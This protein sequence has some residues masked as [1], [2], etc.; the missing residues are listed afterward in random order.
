MMSDKLHNY[1]PTCEEL[2]PADFNH[3]EYKEW[4]D[5]TGSHGGDVHAAALY[6][7]DFNHSEYKE[8]IDS[9]GSH[10]GDVHAAASEIKRSRKKS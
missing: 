8:W 3:S 1:E 10:G 2:Y 6:P 4:I 7:T 5:S 9:T